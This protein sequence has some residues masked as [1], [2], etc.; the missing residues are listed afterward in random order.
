MFLSRNPT[1]LNPKP[2]S[3]AQASHSDVMCGLP[4][5][6]HTSVWVPSGCIRLPSL[7]HL[8]KQSPLACTVFP[9]GIWEAWDSVFGENTRRPNFMRGTC[10]IISCISKGLA[11]TLHFC[12]GGWIRVHV[13]S[14][15]CGFCMNTSLISLSWPKQNPEMLP[16]DG[17]ALAWSHHVMMSPW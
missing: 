15:A 6:K 17:F 7:K 9:R 14:L 2:L 1:R 11:R 5:A 12:K 8:R 3:I 13:P 4:G 10:G 16:R